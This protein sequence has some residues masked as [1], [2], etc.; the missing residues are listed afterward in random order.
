[1]PGLKYGGKEKMSCT[2][3][4]RN[5]CRYEKGGC[6]DCCA[7][8]YLLNTDREEAPGNSQTTSPTMAALD[9]TDLDNLVIIKNRLTLI[10]GD[11][12][13]SLW[14]HNLDITMQRLNGLLK[15]NGEKQ[16]TA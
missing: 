4:G 11:D 7:A 16:P 13:D 2:L 3:V 1:L 12:P 6:A 10:H 5:I 14:L 9:R 8:Q 15:S